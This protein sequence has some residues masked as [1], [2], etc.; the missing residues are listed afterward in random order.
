MNCSRIVGKYRLQYD[1][2][3]LL[4]GNAEQ[5]SGV[6]SMGLGVRHPLSVFPSSNI[7]TIRLD[8]S[9]GLDLFG[10]ILIRVVVIFCIGFSACL[11]AR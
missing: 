3:D 1:F 11:I 10:Y 6:L 7:L 5:Y 8:V 4:L 2:D 9:A